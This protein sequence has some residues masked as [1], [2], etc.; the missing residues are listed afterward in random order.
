[1]GMPVGPWL[2]V[3]M[4]S[5]VPLSQ[6]SWAGQLPPVPA[7]QPFWASSRDVPGLVAASLAAYAPTGT[8]APPVEPPYTARGTPGFAAG[9]SNSSGPSLPVIPFVIDGGHARGS[10]AWT[11]GAGSS[12]QGVPSGAIDGG[13]AGDDSALVDGG[14]S[15][16]APMAVVSGG[17]APDPGAD[18]LDGGDS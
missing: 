15:E 10:G 18:I 1:M 12:W 2:P 16:G 9:T 5:V 13:N 11:I 3:L 7:G 14:F 6:Q 8:T 17:T 4:V